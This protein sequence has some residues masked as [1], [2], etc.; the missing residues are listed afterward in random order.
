M[1][2]RDARDHRQHQ[3]SVREALQILA[4]GRLVEHFAAGLAQRDQR[5]PEGSARLAVDRQQPPGLQAA[6]VGYAC[7]GLDQGPH[8]LLGGSRRPEQAR[9]RRVTGSERSKL[10][11]DAHGSRRSMRWRESTSVAAR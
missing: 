4:A 9:G 7:G 5:A 3:R 10:G 8:F 11:F 2:R 1:L 6:V